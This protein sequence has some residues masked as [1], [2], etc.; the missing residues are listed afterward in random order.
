M[1]KRLILTVFLACSLVTLVSTGAGL[2]PAKP[3]FNKDGTITAGPKRITLRQNYGQFWMVLGRSVTVHCEQ[4][5]RF[6]DGPIGTVFFLDRKYQVD[7][8]ARRVVYSARM[9][10]HRATETTLGDF[11]ISMRLRDDGLIEIASD[12]TFDDPDHARPKSDYFTFHI[13]PSLTGDKAFTLNGKAGQFPSAGTKFLTSEDHPRELVLFP[14]DAHANSSLGI[15]FVDTGRLS[16]K[17]DRVTIFPSATGKLKFLLDFRQVSETSLVQS[18]ETYGGIDYWQNDRLRLPQYGKCRNLVQNPSFENGMTH[19]GY[20]TYGQDNDFNVKWIYRIDD[21]EARIGA[22]SL[23]MRVVPRSPYHPIQIS[24][25]TMPVEQDQAYVVSFYAKAD[26]PGAGILFAGRC[27]TVPL[28]HPSLW[29]GRTS[30]YEVIDISTEWKRYSLVVEPRQRL[31]SLYFG[32]IGR[33]GLEG[34]EGKIWID[35]VQLEQ[36]ELTAYQEKPVAAQLTSVAQGNFLEAR[37]EPDLRLCL[38]MG[39][40]G[41]DG[42]VSIEIADFWGETVVRTS[43]RFI[44]GKDGYCSVPIPEVDRDFPP[45]IFVVTANTKLDDGFECRE[46]FRF[47]VM[48]PLA[49]THRNKD[50]ISCEYSFGLPRAAPD[51]GRGMERLR[52]VGFGSAVSMAYVPDP[53]RMAQLQTYGISLAGGC[54]IID[55]RRGGGSIKVG[56]RAITGILTMLDPSTAQLGE[57]EELCA[58][59]AAQN[60]LVGVWYFSSECPAGCLP[61]AAHLD[62][63]AKFLVATHQG[64]KRGNPRAT[65]QLTGGPSDISLH[66]G[67]RQVREFIEATQKLA[68]GILFDG[69]GGHI[70][71]GTP[72]LPDLDTDVAAFLDM[73]DGTVY[74]G[75]AV[76][77]NEG[78]N[79]FPLTMLEYGIDPHQGNSSKWFGSPVSYDLGDAERIAAAYYAR[80]WLVALKYHKRV[81]T[82]SGHQNRFMFLDFDFTAYS[83]LKVSNTLGRLLGSADFREDIRFAPLVRC[84]LFED[85]RHRPVAALWSHIPDVD[86]GMKE[87]P[88]AVLP[89]TGDPPDVYTLMENTIRPE[90]RADGSVVVPVGPQPLFLVGKPGT[91]STMSRAI[92]FAR[93]LGREGAPTVA[94]SALPLSASEAEVTF[95]NLLSKP[96][97]GVASVSFAHATERIP[98]DLGPSARLKRVAK[99]GTEFACDRL[100]SFVLEADLGSLDQP[101]KTTISYP[102]LFISRFAPAVDGDLG[103][104]RDR[105]FIPLSSGKTDLLS[106][107]IKLAWDDSHLFLAATVNDASATAASRQ[108]AMEGKSR[109]MLGICLDLLSNGRLKGDLAPFDDDNYC[110]EFMPSPGEEK[111]IAFCRHAP[112]TQADSGKMAPRKG[113]FDGQIIAVCRR[114]ADGYVYE[115]AIPRARLMPLRLAKG[116]AFGLSVAAGDGGAG[117]DTATGKTA[118]LAARD[119]RNPGEFAVAVFVE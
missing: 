30:M 36:G 2:V 109:D 15:T 58:L 38:S 94:I 92:R 106:A 40:P 107:S 111:G 97:S 119:W 47:S 62:T 56:D 18:E 31:L 23:L 45:G 48:G 105:P 113:R 9:R 114:R 108:D 84:Y 101:I 91:L 110:Y 87:A 12:Y 115:V 24:T 6:D 17:G 49:N 28:W 27:A 51:S 61:L 46:L 100:E 90:T 85:D 63:F 88:S 44:S 52:A 43:H 41:I 93:L 112:V 79:Y 89:F 68:P 3:V 82:M 72:E 34:G 39:K 81:L 102:V 83:L 80:S 29:K 77:L 59:K 117:D 4:M 5:F 75:C 7:H 53:Q 104:W 11:T 86:R 66:G 71:R 26:R 1:T 8:E 60:P 73:L 96:F 21:K 74:K 116:T 70:Y 55:K 57:F 16:M 14:A 65:V 19:W 103:D 78:M 98:L 10:S 33:S 118:A 54:S 95:K 13:P 35:G 64:V 69:V 37:Q 42:D 99:A 76:N 22:H 25:F 67:V 50:I 32:P 20:R